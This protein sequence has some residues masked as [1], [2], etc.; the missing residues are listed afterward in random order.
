[1]NSLLV[2][3]PSRG[4]PDNI[5]ALQEAWRNTGATADILVALDEDD[6]GKYPGLPGI[7]YEVGPRL[8]MLPT[9]NKAALKYASEYRSLSFMGDDHRPKSFQWDRHLCAYLDETDLGVAYGND[10]LQGA[11][12]PTAVFMRSE[13]VSKLGYMS[14]PDLIHMY[15]DSFWKALGE[16]LGTLR[17]FSDITIE[18]THYSCGKA[19]C[20][21]V[22]QEANAAEVY[23][24]DYAIYQHYLQSQFQ[25]DLRKLRDNA[26]T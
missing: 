8:R 15:A 18:H 22:Y 21:S 3:V 10:L 16:A 9:L 4:R 5:A 13:I 1:M 7:L 23:S 25:N 2:I 24:H 26:T 19:I 11:S 17:Y 20:D 6:A 14:P 12:L